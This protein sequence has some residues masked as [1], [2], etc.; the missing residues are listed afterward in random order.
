MAHFRQHEIGSVNKPDLRRGL[1]P[2]LLCV[3]QNTV[4]HYDWDW[5][6]VIT[7][8]EMTVYLPLRILMPVLLPRLSPES[9]LG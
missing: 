5:T 2:N 1:G 8:D 9:P 3:A 6:P 4:A 7:P